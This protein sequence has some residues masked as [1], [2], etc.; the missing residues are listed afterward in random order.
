MEVITE[1]MKAG[2]AG[3]G[4][5]AKTAEKPGAHGSTHRKRIRGSSVNCFPASQMTLPT[6]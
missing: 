3:R 4:Q 6:A 2:D 5:N 1:V